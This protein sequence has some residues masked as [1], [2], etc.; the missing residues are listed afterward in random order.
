[1][2]ANRILIVLIV[3]FTSSCT[4]WPSNASEPVEG[5]D[6]VLQVVEDYERR[7]FDLALISKTGRSLCVSSVNWPINGALSE[8]RVDT[9]IEVDGRRFEAINGLNFGY[10][11]G[12][13][14]HKI[15]PGG[16]LK[17][18]CFSQS[19]QMRHSSVG[20]TSVNSSFVLLCRSV[21][22]ISSMD[23]FDPIAR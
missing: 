12:G 19:L 23:D 5:N 8:Q 7:R 16:T 17:G 14:G 20:K 10:C 18:Y 2:H 22:R 21:S 9:Y 11:Y 13:C 3:L 4:A 1:M 15:K 6:Y